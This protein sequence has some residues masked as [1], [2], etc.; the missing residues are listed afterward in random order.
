[1][2]TGSTLEFIGFNREGARQHANA[3]RRVANR[4]FEI[5]CLICV[6]ACPRANFCMLTDLA[7]MVLACRRVIFACWR[8]LLQ[9]FTFNFPCP[10]RDV[11]AFP[12]LKL[13]YCCPTTVLRLC[14]SCTTVLLLYYHCTTTVLLYYDCTKAVLLYYYGT[15]TV[16]ILYYCTTTALLLYY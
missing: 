12:V 13:Y 10:G 16:L 3:P 9:F 7:W 14:S 4:A 5:L 11:E 2:Y 15:T 8:A 6:L 1:M